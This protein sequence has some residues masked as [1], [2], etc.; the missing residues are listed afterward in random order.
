[1]AP[2]IFIMRVFLNSVIVLLLRFFNPLFIFLE[3]FV[4]KAAYRLGSG[5]NVLL[6]AEIVKALQERFIEV[7]E[8]R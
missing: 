7:K 6:E 4:E 2:T 1:M 8:K 3:S 5:I